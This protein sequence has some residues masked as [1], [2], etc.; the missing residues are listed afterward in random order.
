CVIRRKATTDSD[1]IRPPVPVNSSSDSDLNS[2][3]FASVFGKGGR[4]DRNRWTDNSGMDY[5]FDVSGYFMMF[6]LRYAMTY[7]AG[8]LEVF[9]KEGLQGGFHCQERGLPCAK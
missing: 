5:P 4:K 6:G 2:T 3:T 9:R 1:L 8:I 7:E